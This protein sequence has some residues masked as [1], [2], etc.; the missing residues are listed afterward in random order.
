MGIKDTTTEEK[1]I[2]SDRIRIKLKDEEDP[3]KVAVSSAL[4]FIPAPPVIN[5]NTGMLMAL[6]VPCSCATRYAYHV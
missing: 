1:G 3:E 6:C 4:P 5:E 2:K